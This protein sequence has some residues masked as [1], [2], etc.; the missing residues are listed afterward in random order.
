MRRMPAK[1]LLPPAVTATATDADE[2]LLAALRDAAPAHHALAARML[3]TEEDARDAVQEAWFRAWR[4]RAHMREEAARHGWLRR[5]V[6]RECLRLLRR[7]ALRAWIGLDS[8]PEPRA[9]TPDP[10]ASV[11]D[12]EQVRRVRMAVDRLPPRQ[13]L[14]WGLR[15]DEGWTVAEIAEAT[16]LGAETIKTHLGRAM[17]TVQ[18]RV[19]AG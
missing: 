11:G 18:A 19:E 7:R 15:F 5:I 13:R 3:G 14:V 16:G 8:A 12:R 17:A 9:W 1:P 10:E 4:H 6:A 2:A